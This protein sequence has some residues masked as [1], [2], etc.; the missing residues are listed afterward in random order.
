MMLGA[1]EADMVLLARATGIPIVRLPAGNLG[2]LDTGMTRAQ[3][4][5]LY[6]R[7]YE[8]TQKW[9]ATPEGTAWLRLP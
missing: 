3:K 6:H 4:I 1:S 8:A 9:L 2:F 5:N 7:G